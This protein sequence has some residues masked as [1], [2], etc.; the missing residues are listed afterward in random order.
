MQ[1]KALV[2]AAA[3]SWICNACAQSVSENEMLIAASALTKVSAAVEAMERYG[4]P[5]PDLVGQAFLESATAHDPVLLQRLADYQVRVL[6]KERHTVLLVCDSRGEQAL[7]EDAGCTGALDS[8]RWQ[9]DAAT[10]CEF[11]IDPSEV[12]AAK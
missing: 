10:R 5:P 4:N 8:H 2:L 7:L 6:R 11:S 3:T 9:G 1:L 12:C